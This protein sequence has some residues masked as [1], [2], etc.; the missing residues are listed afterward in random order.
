MQSMS[1]IGCASPGMLDAQ[2]QFVCTVG[3]A[4]HHSL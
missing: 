2:L 4:D 1:H 3:N